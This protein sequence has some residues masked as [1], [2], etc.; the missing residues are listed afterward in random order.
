MI[1]G[2]AMSGVELSKEQKEKQVHVCESCMNTVV[3][4]FSHSQEQIGQLNREKTKLQWELKNLREERKEQKR[5]M[6]KEIR[7]LKEKLAML[8][9]ES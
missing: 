5:A 1:C 4:T 2:L 7:I 6:E 8:N 9:K 3:K